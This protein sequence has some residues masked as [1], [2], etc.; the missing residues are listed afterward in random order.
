METVRIP[1][2]QGQFALV[3]ASDLALLST[4]SWWAVKS[5]YGFC[6][7]TKI[8]TAEGKRRVVHMHRFLLGDPPDLHVD[9]INRNTL[10][11]RRSNL[12]LATR[13]QNKAN[14]GRYRNNTSGY[15]GVSWNR[16]TRR[17]YAKVGDGAKNRCIG[18]FETAEEA[19]RA[20]DRV[21]RE[22]YGEFASLNFV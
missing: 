13:S 5:P 3:D 17:W 21:A 16:K 7:A 15:K 14:S 4:T 20:Y 9:H 1:L 11:N 19:A 6:A 22:R 10:D 2:T 18:H 8:R 12:R